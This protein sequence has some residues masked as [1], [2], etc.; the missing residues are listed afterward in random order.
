MQVKMLVSMTGH[1]VCHD[2]GNEVEFDDAVAQR[3][4]ERGYA[5]PVKAAPKKKIEV[6]DRAR[7]IETRS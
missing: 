4:I 5:E 6:A 2:V 3:L 7:K 1:A